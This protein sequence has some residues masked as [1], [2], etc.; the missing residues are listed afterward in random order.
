MHDSIA[1][2][3]AH[4]EVCKPA[5]PA[6]FQIISGLRSAHYVAV[7]RPVLINTAKYISGTWKLARMKHQICY[8]VVLNAL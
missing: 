6:S 4:A 5:A 2:S 3:I 8:K 7:G 1:H